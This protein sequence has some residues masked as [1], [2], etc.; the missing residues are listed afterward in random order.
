MNRAMVGVDAAREEV[1]FRRFGVSIGFCAPS[2]A[3]G[4]SAAPT[5]LAR[6]GHAHAV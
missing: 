6:N 4:L 5:G 2:R 1:Y 3:K